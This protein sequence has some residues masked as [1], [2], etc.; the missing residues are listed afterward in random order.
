MMPSEAEK[1]S[2]LVF[3]LTTIRRS[4]SQVI[5]YKN[6]ALRNAE[7]K[8]E[9]EDEEKHVQYEEEAHVRTPEIFLQ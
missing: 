2:A 8:S 4:D 6:E 1:K 9:E 7:E 3:P 5:R